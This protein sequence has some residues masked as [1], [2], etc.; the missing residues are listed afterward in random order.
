MGVYVFKSKHAPWIK[1]GHHKITAS[2]PNVYYRV[3][4]RGFYSCVHPNELRG[5]LSIGDVELIAWYPDLTKRH[6]TILHKTCVTKTGEFHPLE[7]LS[8][9]L[10]KAD[11]LGARSSVS[12]A[13][14]EQALDWARSKRSENAAST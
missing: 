10:A 11:T 9:I 2:R 4:R 12:N 8:N 13:D 14:M 1:V 5:R 7:N 3:A 6:E